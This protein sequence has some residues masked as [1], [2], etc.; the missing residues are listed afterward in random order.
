MRRLHFL[1]SYPHY[2]L[3]TPAPLSQRIGQ[4]RAGI[5]GMSSPGR[6][7]RR[8]SNS[9]GAIMELN[10]NNAATTS[11][12]I[13]RLCEGVNSSNVHYLIATGGAVGS[14]NNIVVNHHHGG[15]LLS[16]I[17]SYTDLYHG[18]SDKQ[19]RPAKIASWLRSPSINYRTIQEETRS[20]RT[21]ETI[22][23]FFELQD[24]MDWVE[25]GL[26]EPRHLKCIG[27]RAYS[28]PWSSHKLRN[29]TFISRRR[30]NGPSVRIDSDPL[31]SPLD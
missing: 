21:P 12:F 28:L 20:I 31:A 7:T 14:H 11:K 2:R 18:K 16:T 13:E 27:M 17:V 25:G 5:L 1:S 30:E 23:W 4:Y 3:H 22:Q 19:D 10:F 15:T 29:T 8:L 9:E 6:N 24:Y 26:R